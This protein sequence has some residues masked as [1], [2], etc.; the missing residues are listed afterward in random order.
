[1]IEANLAR[2]EGRFDEALRLFDASLALQQELGSALGATIANMARC[3]VLTDAGRLDEAV[4]TYESALGELDALEMTSFRSTV[5]ISL[6]EALY[7]QGRPDDAER[8]A[9]EGEE[10]GAAEDVVNFAFGDSLRAQIVADRGEHDEAERLA[11]NALHYAYETDFPDVQAT[12]HAA[13]AH[14]LAAAD[15][16]DEARHELERAIEIWSTYGWLVRASRAR[17]LLVQL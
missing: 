4:A 16:I 17:G 7:A 3:E 14:S 15:R 2:R 9:I 5:T 6:G 1:M 10:L 13:L 11:R 8:L 12:A